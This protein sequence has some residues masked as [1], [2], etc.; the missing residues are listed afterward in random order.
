MGTEDQE[1]VALLVEHR[2]VVPGEHELSQV[3]ELSDEE[4]AEI[5]DASELIVAMGSSPGFRRLQQL[6]HLTLQ[7]IEVVAARDQPTTQE[8]E[9][10]LAGV[11]ALAQAQTAFT[12]W[13]KSL[14]EDAAEDQ[15]S[16]ARGQIESLEGLPAWSLLRAL[17]GGTTRLVRNREG[18]IGIPSAD[19]AFASLSN[20]ITTAFLASHE[21]FKL[22]LIARSTDVRAAGRRLR[23]LHAECPEGRPTLIVKPRKLGGDTIQ[24]TQLTPEDLPMELIGEALRVTR[25]AE[26]LANEPGDGEDNFCIG[27]EDEPKREA[28]AVEDRND[29]ANAD[30]PEN[31]ADTENEEASPQPVPDLSGLLRLASTLNNDLETAWSGALERAAVEN[32]IAKQMAAVRAAVLGYQR[33]AENDRVILRMFPPDDPLLAELEANPERG[34]ELAVTAQLNA[35][36]NV[37]KAVQALS[38]PTQVQVTFS[39]DGP[40]KLSRF[41]ESGAFAQLSGQIDLLRH[42]FDQQDLPDERKRL[43]E[44]F[45]RQQLAHAAWFAGDPEACLFHSA[46]G[47]AAWLEAPLDQ[48]E[49]RLQQLS[50]PEAAKLGVRTLLRV[51]QGNAALDFATLTGPA[52]ADV[53]TDLVTPPGIPRSPS[54]RGDELFDLVARDVPYEPLSDD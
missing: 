20:L 44:A 22:V 47:L 42:L 9:A 11:R 46:C 49:E 39:S 34:V 43:G 3:R 25:L 38:E 17:S 15:A 29:G 13:A 27:T 48:L 24:A 45:R 10:C 4:L 16:E 41:W 37:L 35:F 7:R 28:E 32:G 26:R 6:T 21:A 18:V 51:L 50:A 40:E 1:A 52:L 54:T 5:R 23:L 12:G 19:S 30:G 14:V 31:D 8:I 2:V 33:H 53:L 36:T